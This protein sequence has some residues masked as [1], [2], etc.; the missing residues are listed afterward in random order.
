MR[1]LGYVKA[2]ISADETATIKKALAM[3]PKPT[4][5]L[6]IIERLEKTFEAYAPGSVEVAQWLNDT[7]GSYFAEIAD[8]IE[9]NL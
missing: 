8:W 6:A 9:K 5:A 1:D 7:E 3:W 4:E 2:V